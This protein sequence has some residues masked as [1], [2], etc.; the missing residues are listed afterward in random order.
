[1]SLVV[2]VPGS[3]AGGTSAWP[4]Q[5]MDPAQRGY[6]TAYLSFDG[7]DGGDVVGADRQADLV[8]A[9]MARAGGGHLVAHSAGAVPAMLAAGRP[10]SGV[11]SLTLC[12]PACFG[13][14]RGGPQV[15]AHVAAMTPVFA[16]AD[17][18]AVGDGEFAAAFLAA[19][20]ARAPDPGDPAAR[21][22]GRRLRAAPPPWSSPL[23][24][25]LVRRVPT[26]VL[27]GGWNALYDEVAHSLA[28]AGAEHL[29][30]DGFGHRPQD[31]PAACDAMAAHWD[32]H[33]R[34]PG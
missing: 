26:L 19:L 1:M 29:V 24:A 4:A 16:L 21:S 32:G 23:D 22:L 11:C 25:T 30:L 33:S 8:A 18:A 10:G 17:D 12:E 15:E 14:V 5:A 2:F 13:A 34:P 20:G 6:E 3:G 27:T 9:T 28:A 7:A 31:H